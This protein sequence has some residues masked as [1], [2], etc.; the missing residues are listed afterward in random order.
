MIT[1]EDHNFDH[2]FY[3]HALS[4]AFHLIADLLQSKTCA[5]CGAAFSGVR[6][7][8]YCAA[9][10]PLMKAAHTK[11]ASEKLKRKR[12]AAKQQGMR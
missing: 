2:R 3:P 6:N 8:K 5:R 10:R 9:C 1:K 4:P 11:R 7:A 12:Q